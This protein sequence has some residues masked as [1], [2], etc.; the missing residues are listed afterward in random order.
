MNDILQRAK[1]KNSRKFITV[2]SL[3]GGRKET[4]NYVI[5]WNVVYWYLDEIRGLHT[6]LDGFPGLE[7]GSSNE[8]NAWDFSLVMV[9][10]SK[11]HQRLK[12]DSTTFYALWFH[13]IFDCCFEFLNSS[14]LSFWR[15]TR[16]AKLKMSFKWKQKETR[17]KFFFL[18][19]LRIK[20][21]CFD[22]HVFSK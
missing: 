12:K 20:T 18:V 7:Q 19:I 8:S 17:A 14:L 10:L 2:E 22:K 3:G 16:D 21:V 9:F 1:T 5:W 4:S 13:E 15:K 11:R 6:F